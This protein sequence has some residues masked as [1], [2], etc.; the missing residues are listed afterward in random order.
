MS[1]AIEMRLAKGRFGRR[2]VAS[3]LGVSIVLCAVLGAR[4]EAQVGHWTD[5]TGQ[6]RHAVTLA[7]TVTSD[8]PSA[9]RASSTPDLDPCE[10]AAARHAPSSAEVARH[11]L[12]VRVQVE[13]I[14][15]TSSAANAVETRVLYRLAPK[16]SP[17]TA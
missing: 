9:R 10:L 8:R 4:H 6:L 11:E 16:T 17:P 2:F 12:T 13:L 3:M 5:R 1:D 14:A 15:I 7:T